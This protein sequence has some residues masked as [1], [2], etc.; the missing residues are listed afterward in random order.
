MKKPIAILALGA[1]L[2][3]GGAAAAFAT[4]GVTPAAD[5]AAIAPTADEGTT[6][7]ATKPNPVGE[8]LAELVADG[9]ITQAQADKIVAAL[10]AK[11]A[12]LK[13]KREAAHAEKKAAREAM[14]AAWKQVKGFLEDGVITKEELA[15]LPSDSPLKSLGSG[16][17]DDGQI[18]K[19]ELGSLRG[20]KHF[21]GDKGK[22]LDSGDAP[23]APTP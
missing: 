7:P 22:G 12:D 6:K 20:P 11:R 17:L 13:A 8:V 1:I 15:Q 4:N 10:D 9:T 14:K 2:V 16:I 23:K 19:E 3:L 18:T 21:W 5:P